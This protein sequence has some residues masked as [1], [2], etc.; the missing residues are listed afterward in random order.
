MKDTREII[1]L[2]VD[3]IKA[4]KKVKVI[5]NYLD[6]FLLY[7]L[8]FIQHYCFTNDIT[9]SVPSTCKK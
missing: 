7:P 6:L 8:C 3:T 1:S 4:E 2:Q 5:I 9:V